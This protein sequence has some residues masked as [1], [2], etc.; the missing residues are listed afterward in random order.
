MV[1]K[2]ETALAKISVDSAM[3]PAQWVEGLGNARRVL[4]IATKE[5][6]LCARALVLSKEETGKEENAKGRITAVLE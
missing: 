5:R 3:D 1:E 6:D 2:I 4:D